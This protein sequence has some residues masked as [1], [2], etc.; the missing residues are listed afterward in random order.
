MIKLWWCYFLDGPHP[1]C[2]VFQ[3]EFK[4]KSI[5]RAIDGLSLDAF[6]Y[7][8]QSHPR[9]GSSQKRAFPR[10]LFAAQIPFELKKK[11]NPK[12]KKVFT[13]RGIFENLPSR[14]EIRSW[15]PR[16]SPV[17]SSFLW[18]WDEKAPTKSRSACSGWSLLATAKYPELSNR[19]KDR[20]GFHHKKQLES[21]WEEWI[22]CPFC[23]ENFGMIPPLFAFLYTQERSHPLCHFY[24]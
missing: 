9:W 18:P 11:N 4:E 17:T 13:P 22:M 19:S 7:N 8:G 24:L 12:L 5:K 14:R 16:I 2:L 10:K 21:M 1:Y 6:I 15:C 23:I 3:G 20:T